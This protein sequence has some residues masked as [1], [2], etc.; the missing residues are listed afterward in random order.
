LYYGT[1]KFDIRINI[2]GNVEVCALIC[3]LNVCLVD[4]YR[5]ASAF[6]ER[7]SRLCGFGTVDFDFPFV[8]PLLNEMKVFLQIG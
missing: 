4:V 2:Q 7:E 5:G 6:S 3:L 1:R 8:R